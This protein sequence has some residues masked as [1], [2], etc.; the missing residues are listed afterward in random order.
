MTIRSITALAAQRDLRA[1]S[2]AGGHLPPQKRLPPQL[3]LEARRVN[4]TRFRPPSLRMSQPCIPP[5]WACLP[6][7]SRA[8]QMPVICR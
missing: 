3:K 8:I 5:L 7:C 2:S 6:V 4:L 1:P